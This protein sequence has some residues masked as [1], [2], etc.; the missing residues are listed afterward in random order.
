MATDPYTRLLTVEEFLQIEFGPDMKAELDEGVI[1]MMAGGS[2]D[3]ARVQMNLYR[4]LGAALRGSGC[5]PY[6]S[7][8]AVAGA[9]RSVRYPDVTVDC[10]TASDAPDDRILGDPRV[11][12]EVLSPS[13]RRSD[14]G[15][16][17][18]EY[19]ALPTV[20]TIAFVDPD[21][22]RCR[23]LQR[24]GP[25]AWSDITY[26]GPAPLDLPSLGRSIPHAEIF[27]RD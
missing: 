13:T 1:R 15:V 21:S 11:V 26:S 5:R 18:A 22:E 12:I 24:T 17:L 10:G 16:K 3:H 14:E 4:F 6:G 23:V 9:D 7:D 27:A 8:M 2:R 20:D 19:R 25:S